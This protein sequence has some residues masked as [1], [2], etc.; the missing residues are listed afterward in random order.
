MKKSYIVP[1]EKVKVVCFSEIIASS[2][3]PDMPS[4]DANG[5]DINYG[6]DMEEGDGGAVKQH[7]TWDNEW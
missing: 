2:P 3:D 6:G 4:W 5:G 1:A 7:S